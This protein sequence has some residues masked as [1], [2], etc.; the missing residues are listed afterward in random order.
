[1]R[2]ATTGIFIACLL[3]SAAGCGGGKK[4]AAY[5]K[6][7]T[8]GT[9][10]GIGGN[11]VTVAAVNQFNAAMQMFNNH[12]QAN[13]WDSN[14]CSETAKAFELAID[15]QPDHKFTEALYDAGL[16]YQRCGDDKDAQDRFQKALDEQP[17]F[18]YARA[19]LALYHFKANG[20][21]NGAISE[22]QRAVADAKFNNVPALVDLAMFQMLRDSPDPGG[23][24]CKVNRG[25]AT[26][27]LGDFECAKIN[28]QR[29]LAFDDSYMPAFNQL[30]LYYF[31]NAKKR[32]SG[33]TSAGVSKVSGGAIGRSVATNAAF[34]KHADQQQLDLASLVCSQ[35]ERKNPKYAP[36][37]NTSGLILNENGLINGAVGEFSQAVSLDPRFFEGYMNLA[38]VNLSFRGFDKAQAAYQEALKLHANDYDAHLGLALA[39]RGQITDANYDQLVKLAAAELDTCIKLDPNRPDAYFNKAILTD[40]YLSTHGDNNHALAAYGDATT[41][42]NTFIQK[43]QGKSEYDGAVKAANDRLT[44]INDPDK[45]KVAIIKQIMQAAQTPPPKSSSTPPQGGGGGH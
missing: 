3:A 36:I 22:L 7:S 43:A 34:T 5:A 6:N 41:L 35:A 17:S 9:V 4:D 23:D 16:A 26:S 33:A 1:M 40:E 24:T 32:A 42:L 19:Q 15:E 18:H 8:G 28:L 31:N 44:D 25:G 11:K 21:V 20:D 45:G 2:F 30:A 38:A 12:D 10:K 13:N 37:H 14:A 29:A 27:E 39:Y